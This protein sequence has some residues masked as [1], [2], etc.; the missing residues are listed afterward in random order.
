MISHVSPVL[1]SSVHRSGAGNT[2]LMFRAPHPSIHFNVK[3]NS[4]LHCSN[5][6]V[7]DAVSPLGL[8]AALLIPV[9]L[10]L[11]YTAVNEIRLKA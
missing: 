11:T 2:E 8:G 6:Q 4:S 7:R 1:A 10:H 5:S 3:L 9:E